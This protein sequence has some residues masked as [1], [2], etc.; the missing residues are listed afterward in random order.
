MSNKTYFVSRHNGAK[1]WAI[2]QGFAQ[3]E[4]VSHF[5]PSVIS[6]GD[7]VIGTLPVNLIAEINRRGGEYQHLILNLSESDRGRELSAE[8]M[9]L[10][11]ARLERFFVSNNQFGKTVTDVCEWQES[12]GKHVRNSERPSAIGTEC[13]KQGCVIRLYDSGVVSGDIYVER[14]PDC[15]RL[16]LSSNGED[17]AAQVFIDDD[18]KI[19]A[20]IDTDG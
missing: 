9:D 1:E 18:G 6:E 13:T 19:R 15:W 8:D 11:G 5:D 16:D 3:V 12:E 2:K 4:M 10:L 7:V 14:T 17:I 20:E